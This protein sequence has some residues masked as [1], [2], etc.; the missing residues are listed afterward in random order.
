MGDKV[1]YSR[2]YIFFYKRL[3]NYGRKMTDD[4]PLIEDAIQEVL[5]DIWKNREKLPAVHAVTAY[6]YSSFRYIVLRKLKRQRR[7]LRLQSTEEFEFPVDHFIVSRETDADFK[8]QLHAALEKLTPRQ[9]EAI[10][11]RFYENFSYEEVSVVLEISVKA[12]Y[13]IMARAL[14]QL[15]EGLTLPVFAL[16]FLQQLPDP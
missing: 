3:Y 13:K 4:I 11:L 15:K 12:T 9:R 6:Y 16:V 10:F 2:A 7:S 8:E 5:M 14:R 1:A